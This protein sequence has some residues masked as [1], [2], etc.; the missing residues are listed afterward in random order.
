MSEPR[1][2]VEVLLAQSVAELARGLALL[3]HELRLWAKIN[4]VE[5]RRSIEN[6]LRSITSIVE[7]QDVLVANLAAQ[8]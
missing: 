2:E 5:G 1:A 6:T 7:L 3:D 4:T 8:S